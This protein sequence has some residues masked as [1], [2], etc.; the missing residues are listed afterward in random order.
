M[1]N[2]LKK[3]L[4]LF[5]IFLFQ[6]YFSFLIVL[7]ENKKDHSTILPLFFFIWNVITL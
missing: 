2:R 6:E 3:T 4:I 5:S 7:K 1:V